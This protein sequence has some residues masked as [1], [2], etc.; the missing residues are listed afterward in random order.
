MT[1]V[2]DQATYGQSAS[3]ITALDSTRALAIFGMIIVNVGA[4]DSAGL[5]ALIVSVL[6]GRAAILFI[7]LAGIGVTILARSLKFTSAPLWPSL[8]W[9]AAV[10]MLLGL[11]FQ[12]LPTGVN[13]I[14]MLYAALF[15]CALVAVRLPSG[16]LQGTAAAMTVFGPITYIVLH[17]VG[18]LPEGPASLVH[19]PLDSAAA[20]VL[21]G[22]YPL[23]VWIAPFLF[24]MWLGRLDLRSPGVH[25]M[26]IIAGAVTAGVCSL[27]SW[28]LIRILGE[29]DAEQVGPDHLLLASGHSQMPL[30][31]LSA[32]GTSALIIGTMLILTPRLGRLAYP[33]VVT[34]QLALTAYCLHL[35]AIAVLVRPAS[36]NPNRGLL[37]SAVIIGLIIALCVLWR[38]FAARGPFET[39]LRL[40]NFLT[41]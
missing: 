17:S 1:Q 7:V 16:W 34:G 5:P 15:V 41:R 33:L 23:I 27:A 30:W 14:L 6:H 40:P 4:A 37:L 21:T 35:A 19:N 28:A 12:Q 11:V 20:I 2:E 24:G 32:V 3:R 18:D 8:A 25:R 38:A 26:L 22:P 39:L 36:E 9:R 29:P 13:V 10:L 31:V